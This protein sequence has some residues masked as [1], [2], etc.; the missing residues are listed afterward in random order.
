MPMSND[1]K[2]GG[3]EKNGARS[4]KYCSYCYEKGE[5][6]SPEINTPQKMQKLC[7]E[8]MKE[9]GMNGIIAWILTRF[10]PYLERWKK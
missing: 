8:K 7:I 2:L 3:S 1:P 5:F 4:S 9:G 6:L 10:V